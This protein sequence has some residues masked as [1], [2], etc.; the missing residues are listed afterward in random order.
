MIDL[1]T[2]SSASDGSLSPTELLHLAEK[3]GI[4]YLALTDHNTTN[5]LPEFLHAAKSCSVHAIPGV[6]ITC[7]ADNEELHILALNLPEKSFPQVQSVMK[8]VLQRSKNSQLDLIS[9]LRKAGYQL[10]YEEIQKAN[11]TSVLNRAHIGAALMQAGYVPSVQT[12]FKTLLNEEAGYYHP[13]KRLQAVDV[14]HMIQDLGAIPV[15]AHPFFRLNANGVKRILELLAPH[16]LKGMETY[17][18]TYTPEQT[19]DA[20]KL[21]A[22]FQ[23]KPSGG[24]D[25]HGS[26]KPDIQLGVGRGNLC[27]PEKVVTELL[28]I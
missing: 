11:P 8:E 20:F 24:S 16:G 12:A 14:L 13:A 17:Y 22:K 3:S 23:L 25:F 7:E 15:W 6:E 2:H 5:G 26:N 19:S 1:H 9:N 28:K 21:A 18:S 10:S 4:S 27:I